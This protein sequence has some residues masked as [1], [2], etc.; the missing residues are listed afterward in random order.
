MKKELTKHTHSDRA[1]KSSIVDNTLMIHGG[2]TGPYSR[3]ALAIPEYNTAAY[4]FADTAELCRYQEGV[5]QGPSSQNEDEL[6]EYGRYGN[7]TVMNLEK[8]LAAIEGGEASATFTS[9]MG[10]IA[11]V[12]FSHVRAGEHF[13]IGDQCYRRTRQLCRDYIAKL[14][15]EI[16]VVGQSDFSEIESKIRP[17]TKLIISESPTNPYLRIV[18][19]EKLVALA[20]K[21]S[22]TTLID[23]SLASPV[24]LRPIEWGVDLVVHSATKYLSGHNDL[25][26]GVV[27]GTLKG[28][29]PIR[30]W[31]DVVGGIP[32]ASTAT[33]LERSLKT[34]HLRVTQQNNTTLMVAQMLQEHPKISRVWYPGLASH[35]DHQTAKKLMTGFGGVVSFEINGDLNKTSLFIDSVRLLKIA[36]SFGSVD[37]LI[38]QPALVSFY[39]LTTEQRLAVGIKDNL[40][41][42][43]VGIEESEDIIADL[44]NALNKI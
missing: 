34:L 22:I 35:P 26:A 11:A 10:S 14:G 27:V 19:L 32:D 3:N 12:I 29:E 21:Y 8:R 36:P 6:I 23:S 24:N 41:R 4:T 44:N 7:P 39:E 18:D 33:K 43:A 9:G 15:I 28:I 1:Y 40:V 37:S 38:E 31:R 25:M 30:K 20:R 16:S 17:E 13:I 5:L 2:R 42:L